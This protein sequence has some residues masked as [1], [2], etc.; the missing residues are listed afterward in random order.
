MSMF[1]GK[2]GLMM[3]VANEWSIGWAISQALYAEGAELAFTHLPSPSCQR[4]V[5]ALVEPHGPKVVLPCDVQKDAD[6]ARL[7]ERDRPGLRPARFPG[8]LD[9]LR[10]AAGIAAA[11]RRNQPRGLAP[12]DG[13]QRL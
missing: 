2:I 13:H 8:P 11:L 1:A 3:G 4:R 7:F 10:P 9:R 6:I 5:T 12:G